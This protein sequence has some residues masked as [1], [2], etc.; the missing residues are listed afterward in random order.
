M[1][2]GQGE[3]EEASGGAP[4]SQQEGKIFN[5]PFCWMLLLL[6]GLDLITSYKVL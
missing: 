2:L 4:E 3:P 6:Q 5:S 1:F